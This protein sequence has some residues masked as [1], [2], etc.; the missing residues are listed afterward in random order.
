MFLIE[1]NAAFKW[2][3]FTDKMKLDVNNTTSISS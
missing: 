1:V 3:I 2:K